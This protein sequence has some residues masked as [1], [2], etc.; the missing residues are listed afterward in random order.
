MSNSIKQSIKAVCMKIAKI[1][2]V[3]GYDL[4]EVFY[5]F[6]YLV[7]STNV[8]WILRARPSHERVAAAGAIAIQMRPMEGRSLVTHSHGFW[9]PLAVTMAKAIQLEWDI[10]ILGFYIK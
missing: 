1:G 7:N 2:L 4:P 9:P 5:V 3:A 6:P 8:I 10:C